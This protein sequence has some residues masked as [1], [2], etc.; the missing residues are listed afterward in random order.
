MCRSLFVVACWLLVAWPVGAQSFM[1]FSWRSMGGNC[2]NWIAA[3]GEIGPD[4]ADDFRRHIGADPRPG[5][6]VFINSPGGNVAAAIKLGQQFRRSGVLISIGKTQP[7]KLSPQ[8]DEVVSGSCYSAC[9]FAF[10]G[11]ARR[12]YDDGTKEL[13]RPWWGTW[14]PGKQHLGVHQFYIDQATQAL[15]SRLAPD[16]EFSIGLSMSQIITGALVAYAMEMGVDP[17]IVTLT[18]RAGPSSMHILT[19]QD[20]VD[21]R[22]SNAVDPLPTWKLRPYRGGL[23]AF[24]TGS[25][26]VRRFEA[27]ITCGLRQQGSLSLTV[28]TPVDFGQSNVRDPQSVLR[29][30]LRPVWR[31]EQR[32]VPPREI[33]APSEGAVHFNGVSTVAV[34][35][36]PAALDVLKKGGSLT[37]DSGMPRAVAFLFVPVTF[38]F[39]NVGEV[40]SLLQKNCPL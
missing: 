10:M 22:L 8:Y 20:A 32:G 11:G 30:S 1:Q 15:G 36:G 4:T 31:V 33:D 38:E 28:S 6:V 27:R 25:F 35:I 23:A 18:A 2:C 24:A 34:T 5:Q 39:P 13:L 40:F 3:D 7:Q 19:S 26:D 12:F 37:L 21:L 17:R 14:W 16:V 29:T 9:V